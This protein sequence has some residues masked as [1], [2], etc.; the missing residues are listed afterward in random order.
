LFL[1]SPL[2]EFDNNR[3]L[4]C[5]GVAG[6]RASPAG[7]ADGFL[8]PLCPGSLGRVFY[9]GGHRTSQRYAERQHGAPLPAAPGFPLPGPHPQP[10]YADTIAQLAPQLLAHNDRAGKGGGDTLSHFS[11]T[12]HVGKRQAMQ[13]PW[14]G[15]G[16]G[17][18]F[19]PLPWTAKFLSAQLKG[20]DYKQNE[21]YQWICSFTG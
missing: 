11:L 16:G 18:G 13:P 20:N 6:A 14:G 17:L 8:L 19:S 7:K 2:S 9:R 5:S 15:V 1:S 10:P 21:N 4:N 3:D 12:P